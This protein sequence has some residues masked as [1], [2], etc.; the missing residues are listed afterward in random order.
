[1][2]HT[3]IDKIKDSDE[4]KLLLKERKKITKPL[5]LLMLG[6]YYIYILV[7][8][9]KP[10]I[11]GHPIGDGPTT[12]GIV[13]G[14]GVILFTFLVTGLAVKA[15]VKKLEPITEALHAKFGE[16]DAS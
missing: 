1:M 4:Y 7:I 12:V 11:F 8:A 14:I 13:V 5:A 3:T 2:A 9:F 15:S 16:G 6:V 10:D